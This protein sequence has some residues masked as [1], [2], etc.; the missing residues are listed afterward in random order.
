[1][2]IC[3]LVC[4]VYVRVHPMNGIW[5]CTLLFVCLMN[6]EILSLERD[7]YLREKLYSWDPQNFFMFNAWIGFERKWNINFAMAGIRFILHFLENFNA[8]I[9]LLHR[10]HLLLVFF[11]FL[12]FLR[13]GLGASS[14]QN[15]HS[16]S[17]V[18]C[19]NVRE[20]VL[21]V[22]VYLLRSMRGFVVF[23]HR[24]IVARIVVHSA[25][26]TSVPN[27]WFC[28]FVSIVVAFFLFASDYGANGT[29]I[30]DF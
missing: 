3:Y 29:T 19:F 4:F 21:C 6:F 13:F 23:F 22:F 9:P 25:Y 14:A 5:I 30:V 2:D 20:R 10:H 12:S 7:L 24:F 11:A 8:N 15:I 27:D 28:G 16:E 17:N 26:S 1:M 18:Y